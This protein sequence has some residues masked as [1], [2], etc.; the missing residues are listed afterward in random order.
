[1]ST[2]DQIQQIYIGLLGRAADPEG[3]QYWTQEIN[4]G[5]LTI[6]QLRANIVNE[7]P[8]YAAGLGSLTRAQAVT[9]LY[10]NLFDRDPEP[11]GLTYW[12]SGG[13]ASVNFD[14]LVLA[15]V[16]GAQGPDI[17]ALDNKTTIANYYTAQ[18]ADNSEYDPAEARAAVDDVNASTD[19]DDARDAVD[20]LLDDTPTPVEGETYRL[21]T[22]EDTLTGTSADDVFNARLGANAG[23]E[24]NTLN[25][26][27]VLDGGAGSNDTLNAQL[28]PTGTVSDGGIVVG[29]VGALID[30]VIEELAGI[31]RT[32]ATNGDIEGTLIGGLL[33]GTSDL[34]YDLDFRGTVPIMT[35]PGVAIGPKTDGIEVVNVQQ[36]AENTDAFV[37]GSAIDAGEMNG[38]REWWSDNS[39]DFLQIEDIRSETDETFFGMR[40]TDPNVSY[41]AYFAATQLEAQAESVNSALRI[42]IRDEETAAANEFGDDVEVREI[43]FTLGGQEVVVDRD[44]LGN[45]RTTEELVAAL[46]AELDAQGL[47]LNVIDL[48]RNGSLI[49]EDPAGREFEKGQSLVSDGEGVIFREQQVVDPSEY[50]P[51]LSTN[52]VLDQAGNGSQGGVLN[53][54]AMSGDEGLGQFDVLVGRDSHLLSMSS[55]NMNPGSQPEGYLEVVNI[56]SLAG[57][58]GDLTLGMLRGTNVLTGGELRSVDGRAYGFLGSGLTDVRVVDAGEF[59]GDLNAAIN[60][61]QRSGQRVDSYFRDKGQYGDEG[62]DAVPFNY[63]AGNGDDIFTFDL[64]D[65]QQPSF[66]GGNDSGPGGGI[67]F[68]DAIEGPAIERPEE[69]AENWGFGGEGCCDDVF[70]VYVADPDNIYL[71]DD[72]EMFVEGGSGND[73]VNFNNSLVNVGAREDINIDGGEGYDTVEVTTSSTE[74]WASFENVEQL[75]VAGSNDTQH[76]LVDIDG[77]VYEAVGTGMAGLEDVRISTTLE[78]FQFNGELLPTDN[79]GLT[80]WSP[81]LND[82]GDV[83][84]IGVQTAVRGIEEQTDVT[85][86]GENQTL[87]ATRFDN[88]VDQVFDCI[89]L[90]GTEDN[91]EIQVTLDNTARGSSNSKAAGENAGAPADVDFNNGR[92]AELRVKTLDVTNADDDLEVATLVSNGNRQAFNTV[93]NMTTSAGTILLEGTQSLNLNVTEMGNRGI[94]NPGQLIDAENLTNGL[95]SD[96]GSDDASLTL[97]LSDAV[98]DGTSGSVGS[99]GEIGDFGSPSNLHVRGTEGEGDVLQL[100]GDFSTSMRVRE[101][102]TVQFGDVGPLNSDTSF[103]EEVNGVCNVL[104]DAA[105][106][107]EYNASNDEGVDVYDVANIGEEFLISSLTND[108][109]VVIRDF[110]LDGTGEALTLRGELNTTS[111]N[112]VLDGHDHATPPGPLAYA[113]GELNVENAGSVTLSVAEGDENSYV[114]NDLNLDTTVTDLTVRGDITIDGG[115]VTDA[116]NVVDLSGVIS[117]DET[118]GVEVTM[119]LIGAATGATDTTFLLGEGGIQ[120]GSATD[121]TITI[122]D[123][124]T[125]GISDVGTDT[126]FELVAVSQDPTDVT[127]WVIDGFTAD[128]NPLTNGDTTGLDFI[129]LSALEVNGGTYSFGDLSISDDGTDTTI[130]SA[131]AGDTNNWEI[132]LNGVLA[133]DITAENFV[134]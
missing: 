45:P 22:E 12:V 105:A 114:I 70:D 124:T 46:Q 57:A 77:D 108:D 23:V 83:W 19:L 16:D 33:D 111:L 44:A 80:D 91:T 55:I 3:L 95:A 96:G 132:Q 42:T 65:T 48:D 54:G 10:Q 7:Q 69:E 68:G 1:M 119:T 106:T 61:T 126:T 25:S 88:D 85:I 60:L 18:L 53:I 59:D 100:Y 20:A 67:G 21:T 103:H 82:N 32:G 13:G 118:A 92:A 14:Q 62:T 75:V 35:G 123:G 78:G 51:L 27:D 4:D 39:R 107:G 73:R 128:P 101:F 99:S 38:V 34:P 89:D 109:T 116:L 110:Q 131:V 5:V 113:F 17:L 97:A 49:I 28:V 87:S 63:T 47:D 102:E 72:F 64:G 125:P 129:D 40:E 6:E 134:A 30:D 93:Q 86:S 84:A 130:T 2:T 41:T 104:D 52:V 115:Q 56:D 112:I 9:Q 50:T 24:G 37:N 127:K 26:S 133:T 36:Q 90:I 29:E 117:E 79:W 43:S 15:L 8:E 31:V 121:G 74:A 98:T 71:D 94:G 66:S 81:V 122:D 58:T 11:A 120:D 76:N